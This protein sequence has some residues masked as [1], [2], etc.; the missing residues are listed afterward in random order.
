VDGYFVWSLIDNFEW[1]SGYSQRFG[2]VHVDYETQ[3][4]TPRASYH[5]YRE[6]IAR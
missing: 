3:R 5:W 1:D 4:R 6:R 2:L